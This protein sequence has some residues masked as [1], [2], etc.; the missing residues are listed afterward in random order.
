M[1]EAWYEHDELKAE[2]EGAQRQP[3]FDPEIEEVTTE[4]ELSEGLQGAFDRINEIAAI[5]DALDQ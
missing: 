3:E 4:G 2:A 5:V 1:P